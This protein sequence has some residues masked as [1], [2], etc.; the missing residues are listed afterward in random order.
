MNCP[1]CNSNQICVY[2]S[3]NKKYVIRKRKCLICGNRW[4]TIEIPQEEYNLMLEVFNE[5][6]DIY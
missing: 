4:K 5:Q 3:R 2:D 1:K 6:N